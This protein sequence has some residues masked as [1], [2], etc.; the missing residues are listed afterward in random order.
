MYRYVFDASLDETPWADG[1]NFL[2]ADRPILLVMGA[3]IQTD[4]ERFMREALAR[5]D[6][7]EASGEAPV[8]ALVVAGGQVIGAGANAPIASRDPTA[9]A[10][11]IALRE[12]CRRLDAYRL[13]GAMLYVT[14]EPCAMCA[15]ALVHARIK[16]LVFGTRDLRFG[17]VRSKFRLADSDLL[18]HRVEIVEGVLAGECLRRLKRFFEKRRFR[19]LGEDT[20]RVP[21]TAESG[22]QVRARVSGIPAR[23]AYWPQQADDRR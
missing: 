14:M 17:A 20:E 9:H 5:A 8:G 2:P 15:G 3:E 18:N 16:R 23:T 13:T 11:I 22:C 10:E 19:A 4:D 12:A 1:Q 21:S 7:A 6:E